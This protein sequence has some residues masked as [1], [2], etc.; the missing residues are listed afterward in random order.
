M[1]YPL[2]TTDSP[3]H[4]KEYVEEM[5]IVPT[6]ELSARQQ[7]VLGRLVRRTTGEQRLAQR[8]RIVLAAACE[9]QRERLERYRRELSATGQLPDRPPVET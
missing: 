3:H 8:A 7:D 6:I 1:T 2:P 4:G 9:T 5:R